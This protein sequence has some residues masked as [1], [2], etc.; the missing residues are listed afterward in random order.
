MR[1]TTLFVLAAIA[2]TSC[3]LQIDSQYGMRWEQRRPE[4]R[5]RRTDFKPIDAQAATSPVALELPASP[6][7]SNAALPH[8]EDSHAAN[9]APLIVLETHYQA[10]NAPVTNERSTAR[11]RSVSDDAHRISP[12]LENQDKAQRNV[13]L[14]TLGVLLFI[15][16][17]GISF[18][19]F[20]LI[21]ISI[22][23]GGD[24][25]GTLF[26]AL[27][28]ILGVFLVVLGRKMMRR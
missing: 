22:G 12:V 13:L 23:F 17:A 1:N 14:K 19:S 27:F 7:W 26:I 28:F 24:L 16:G 2:A 9:A 21:Y 15:L 3:S 4:Q 6:S 20:I 18:I 25:L 5:H 10:F 8:R 11:A